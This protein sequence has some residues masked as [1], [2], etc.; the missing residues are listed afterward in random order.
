MFGVVGGLGSGRCHFRP[1][2]YR[3]RSRWVFL[4]A[5]T[6][7]AL[8]FAFDPAQVDHRNCAW[9]MKLGMGPWRR[10]LFPEARPPGTW[11]KGVGGGGNER[12]ALIPAP[13]PANLSQAHECNLKQFCSNF[14][15]CA[16]V[17]KNNGLHPSS[18]F[19]QYPLWPGCQREESEFHATL[20][21]A[22]P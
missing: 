4:E 11:G 7:G 10:L 5:R 20:V 6:F 17:F 16:D 18:H 8:F 19:T 15:F 14:V 1:Q 22:M 2:R 13:S 3:K 9:A 21:E 12:F